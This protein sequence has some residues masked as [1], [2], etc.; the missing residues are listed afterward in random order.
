[1]IPSSNGKKVPTNERA[2]SKTLGNLEKIIVVIILKLFE[3]SFL[4]IFFT[5]YFYR[6]L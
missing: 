5:I 6:L 3:Q 1:M 2:K 4:K